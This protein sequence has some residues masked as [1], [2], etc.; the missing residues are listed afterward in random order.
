MKEKLSKLLAKLK[1][2]KFTLKQLGATRADIRALRDAG[3]NISAQTSPRGRVYFAARK[4]KRPDTVTDLDVL[5]AYEEHGS[6]RWAAHSLSMP[7]SSFTKKYHQAKKSLKPKFQVRVLHDDIEIISVGDSI[8]T[9]EDA[10]AKAEIDLRLWEIAETTINSWEVAGK[11]HAGQDRA[12]HWKPQKLW[13]HPLWQVKVKLRRR[14]PKAIQE[15]IKDLLKE[16][17]SPA[18]KPVRRKR[19]ANRDYLLEV[20]LF[21][22]H[23][24]K[25]CWGMETG[26]NYDLDVAEHDYVQAIDDLLTTVSHLPVEKIIFPLGNDFF[27]VNNWLNTTARGTNVDA[28]DD[29]FQKVFRVGCKAVRHAIDACREVAPVEALW[30]P[31]NHDPETSWYMCEWLSA[32]FR[33]DPEVEFDNGPEGR[34]YRQHG[35]VLLAYTHGD[36]IKL[37][38]L[39]LLMA[40]EQPTL[41]ADTKYRAWRCGH[42]H[43]KAQTDYV[44]GDTFNGVKVDILPSISGTDSWHYKKGFVKNVRTAEAYLWSRSKGYVGHFSVGVDED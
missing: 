41:W 7:E 25:L 43:K 36:E 35:K 21:D 29:R 9:V 18:K 38:R 32:F 15:A 17:V 30:V 12:G 16:V 23:F 4:P 39:P 19:S 8:R 2:G 33:N 13:H 31:G 26:E 14:A 44:A 20:V 34:K 3:H 37:D 24:G 10:L 28:V 11:I 6:Y 5:R 1:R 42:F 27:H 40:A 22:A